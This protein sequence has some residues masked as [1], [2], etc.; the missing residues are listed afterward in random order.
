MSSLFGIENVSLRRAEIYVNKH[1]G[2]NCSYE[3]NKNNKW[4]LGNYIMDH[5]KNDVNICV[6]CIIDYLFNFKKYIFLEARI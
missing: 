4:M 1:K 3:V 6:A 5:F 2:I